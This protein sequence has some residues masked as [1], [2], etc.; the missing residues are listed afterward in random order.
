MRETQRSTRWGCDGECGEYTVLTGGY[1]DTP[2][3]GWRIIHVLPVTLN[4]ALEGE[5][6]KV[7]SLCQGCFAKVLGRS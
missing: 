3:P 6:H 2:P 4:M 7:L 1:Q 5:P